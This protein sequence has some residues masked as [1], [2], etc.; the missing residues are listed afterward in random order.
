ML[1][2]SIDGAKIENFVFTD[3]DSST[4]S[5]QIGNIMEFIAGE[6]CKYNCFR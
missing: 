2:G 1:A 6:G 5:V 3:E 4:G